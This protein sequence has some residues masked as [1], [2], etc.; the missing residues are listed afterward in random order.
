MPISIAD[1]LNVNTSQNVTVTYDMF[2]GSTYTSGTG[3]T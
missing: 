3:L 2:R 1:V